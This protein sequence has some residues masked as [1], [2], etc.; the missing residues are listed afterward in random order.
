M[1]KSSASFP[2]LTVPRLERIPFLR[3][4]FGTSSWQVQS[5]I[6]RPQWKNFS[7][8]FLRQIHSNVVHRVSSSFENN[9]EGD[10]MITDQPYILLIIKTAD[11]LPVMMVD[12]EK[13]VI[14]AVHCGW[15]GTRKRLIQRVVKVLES[16]Y[17]CLPSSLLAAM[18]PCIGKD[19]YEVGGEVV[20]G[21][22][23]D[24]HSLDFFSPHAKKKGK[25]LFDLKKAN[26]SQLLSL[27]VKEGNVFS[28]DFCSHCRPH[29]PS[30]RREGKRAG[31]VLSFIGMSF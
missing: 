10:A 2:F 19:C 11:C 27:G 20:Q 18:G 31:R 5:F 4:G 1:M 23:D 7:L 24:G 6:K 16:H 17:E 28:V 30:Y 14:A 25:Y 3:H 13:K 9:V 21:F 8:I 15:R 26:I 29:F 22:E 12:E